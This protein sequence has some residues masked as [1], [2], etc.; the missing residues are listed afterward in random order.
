MYGSATSHKPRGVQ[1]KHHE[2]TLADALLT[3]VGFVTISAGLF[4]AGWGALL[5]LIQIP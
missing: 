1:P 4:G 5:L 3:L 2:Q